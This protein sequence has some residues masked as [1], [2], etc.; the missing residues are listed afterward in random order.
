[1]AMLILT[2]YAAYFTTGV[3][4]AINVV[5][6]ATLYIINIIWI[7]GDSPL[8]FYIA[9]FWPGA[10]MIL[11][12]IMSLLTQKKRSPSDPMAEYQRYIEYVI[13]ANE[14]RDLCNIDMVTSTNILSGLDELC[15]SSESRKK[16]F[17]I[18]LP[19][20]EE[21]LKIALLKKALY[22]NDSEVKHYAAT[23]LTAI[24]RE[25]DKYIADL[26]QKMETTKEPEILLKLISTYDRYLQS[27]LL[28][29]SLKK[30]FWQEYM[31]LLIRGRTIFPD[32]Y[33]L[34][35]KL[36][37]TYIEL[38]MFEQATDLL[39]GKEQKFSGETFT[40]IL[41][42]KLNY[43][44]RDYKRV[45]Q[46]ALEVQQAALDLPAAFKYSVDYWCQEKT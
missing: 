46:N 38:Q 32:D 6:V 41:A 34:F 25:F 20:H 17:I 33:E 12:S 23:L 8:P 14:V 29:H 37:Y 26:K 13:P 22:D 5:M 24:E 9:L 4:F 35:T 28:A 42:M 27:G 45:A 19:E 7:K 21:R 30:V 31:D 15:Y 1:M 43:C 10:G 36:F 3:L 2:I 39:S 44:L 18:K 40:S 11:L 16:E